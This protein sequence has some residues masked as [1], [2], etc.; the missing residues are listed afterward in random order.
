VFKPTYENLEFISSNDLFKITKAGTVN[1]HENPRLY[2]YYWWIFT[3]DSTTEG[4]DFLKEENMLCYADY[5]QKIKDIIESKQP[6]MIYNT[7]YHR[8][9]KKIHGIMK[10]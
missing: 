3:L 6:A 8:L 5:L 9:D 7:K 1:I 2:K 10:N 4:D